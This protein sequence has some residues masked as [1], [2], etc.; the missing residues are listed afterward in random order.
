LVNACSFPRRYDFK[1][2][3][4]D[5]RRRQSRNPAALSLTGAAAIPYKSALKREGAFVRLAMT[6]ATSLIL[7]SKRTAGGG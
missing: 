5:W 6:I 7:V 3:F 1:R 4:E 2:T